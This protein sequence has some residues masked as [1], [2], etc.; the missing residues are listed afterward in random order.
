MFLY[1]SILAVLALSSVAPWCY[2]FGLD[3]TQLRLDAKPGND[4]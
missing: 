3:K 4:K 2:G 1:F